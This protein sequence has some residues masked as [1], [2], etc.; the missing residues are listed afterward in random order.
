MGDSKNN[1]DHPDDPLLLHMYRT[2]L[3]HIA[4]H[5]T[6]TPE[7]EALFCAS[8]QH[9]V[10]RKH[11]YLLQ[12]GNICQYDY[13][14]ISGCLR[15]YEVDEKGRENIV[16][17]GFEEWWMTDWYS[18][19][20]Q[21]PTIYNIDALEDSE[22]LMMPREQLEALFREIPALEI[23]FRRIL[24]QA[25]SSLQRRVLYLQKPAEERYAEFISRYAWFEQRVSQQYIAAYLGITRETLNRLKAQHRKL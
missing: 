6:F 25:F 14:V 13:F 12:E 11:Q 2:I 24:L 10:V 17:F 7:E 9:K 21:T 1:M 16:Q 4:R 20:S 22:V 18:M 19:L 8:L 3:Q 15:Q 5:V 23:Y